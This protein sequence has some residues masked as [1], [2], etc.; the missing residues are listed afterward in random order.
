MSDIKFNTIEE[1]IADFKDILAHEE[2]VHSIIYQELLEIQE[3]FGDD[4]RTELMV[5]EVLSIEDED[6]IEE[7]GTRFFRA[8]L[9]GEEHAVHQCAEAGQ[10]QLLR[11]R[12]DRAVGYGKLAHLT[13]E[14]L[15]DMVAVVAKN[16]GVAQTKLVFFVEGC[17]ERRI[18]P[19]RFKK[20]PESADQDFRLCQLA[21]FQLFPVSAVDFGIP[22][23]SLIRAFP[24]PEFCKKSP[25]RRFFRCQKI[26]QRV[27]HIPKNCCNHTFSSSFN[28]SPS[29]ST[30]LRTH[31]GQEQSTRPV[32]MP[33]R[34]L[35]IVA[36]HFS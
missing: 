1:A 23:D 19:F 20:F 34:S 28:T 32:S 30:A 26:Q 36:P 17:G 27:V 10:A 25:D 12:G 29:V 9:L 16:D 21:V 7:D 31:S 13:A 18:Q 15:N 4:R 22:G 3:K 2:R 8:E 6:L 5:G 24:E 35:Q 14:G 11:L 33:F